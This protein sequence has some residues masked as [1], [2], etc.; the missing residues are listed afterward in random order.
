MKILR[1]SNSNFFNIMLILPKAEFSSKK[2]CW[3]K[4]KSLEIYLNLSLLCVSIF[5]KNNVKMQQLNVFCI[6]FLEKTNNFSFKVD[7][8]L[9]KFI[10]LKFPNMCEIL[11]NRKGKLVL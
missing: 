2:Y 4:V 9:F 10:K 3:V 5:S 11:R 7:Y 1:K 6:H 8:I